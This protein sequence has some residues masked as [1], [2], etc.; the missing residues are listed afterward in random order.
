MPSNRSGRI[1]RILVAVA[2][3]LSLLIGAVTAY[4]LVVLQINEDTGGVSGFHPPPGPEATATPEATGP[5]TNQS[6][7][8]LILGSDSRTGLDSSQ[9]NDFGTNTDI[10]GSARSDV[11]MLVHTQVGEKTTILSFPRDLW[12]SIPGH[13]ENKINASF[14]GGVTGGGPLL[15]AKTIYQLTG[16]KITHFLYVDLAGFQKVVDTIGGVDMCIPAYD[17]NTPGNVTQESAAGVTTQVY[18]AAPNHI[19]DPN[20]GLDIKPGCQ[21]LYGKQALAYVR[22]RSLPCDFIPDFGRI[23]RQQAFLRSVLNKLLQPSE[24]P[25]LPGIVQP[26]LSSLKRDSEFKIGDLVYLV[27]QLQGVSTGDVVFRDVPAT[28]STAQP[29]WSLIPLDILKMQPSA[30]PLFAALRDG[31][32]LPAVAGTGF[33]GVAPSE[34]N[35][36]I[37][38]VDHASAGKAAGV[39][40][41][42]SQA[43]FIAPGVVDYA[44]FGSNVKGT[45]IAYAP[46]HDAEAGVVSKY[47]GNLKT[48]QVPASQLGDNVVA[49]FVTAAYQPAPVGTGANASECPAAPTP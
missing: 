7:N 11:I 36:T 15:V 9:Q 40:T 28:P 39:E 13:G 31:K 25:R 49:L 19:V 35:I 29:S 3:S 10:G 14:E 26:V 42:L 2:A 30:K 17:V 32:P 33:T 34:A 23:N 41:L 12:V 45:V 27:G 38:V 46:G 18:Y 37:P 48:K 4:G 8:Y 21:T 20:T 22:S 24:L 1:S 43:G 6:C 5:C 44:T 47:F 16:L